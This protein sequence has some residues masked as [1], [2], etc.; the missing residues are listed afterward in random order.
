MKQAGPLAGKTIAVTRPLAQ[1][2]ELASLIAAAGGT[3]LRVPLLEI[4]PID[5]K[6][7][8]ADAAKHLANAALAVF[9]SPNAVDYSLPVLL[10]SGPWPEGVQ[11]AAVGQGTARALKAY[12]V[13][14]VV[15]PSQRYDSE[16][17]LDLPELQAN[18][19]AGRRVFIFRG[20]GGR[21]L[22]A[23]TLAERGACVEGV[24]CYRRSA[25]AAGFAPLLDAWRVGDLAALTVSSSEGLRNLWDGLDATGRQWLAQTP[26]FVPHARIGECA[27]SLGLHHIIVTGPADDG[28]IA[29]L[30]A[31]NWAQS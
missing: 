9:I 10:V 12:G 21:E 30:C 19:L 20:E 28:I 15:V 26:I 1:A 23:E 5:N 29:G 25:P 22:L 7:A 16:S 13:T 27:N 3:P 14:R 18:R 6:A 31:Y 11:V 4:G 2:G 24:A 17:L 8:L